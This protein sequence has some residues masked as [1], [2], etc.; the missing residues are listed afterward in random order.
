MTI[1]DIDF[2]ALY[3]Q[4][5]IACNH[6]HLPPDKWDKKAP[7]MAENLVGKPSCYNAQ[8]M[9]AMQ[10]QPGYI[11]RTFGATLSSGLRIGLQHGH[12]GCTDRVQTRPTTG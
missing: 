1:D 7:K 3:K 4:H 2:N 6:Y 11:C 12:V 9:A 8:L 5:L 10:M